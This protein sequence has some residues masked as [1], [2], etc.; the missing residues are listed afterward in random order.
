MKKYYSTI[1]NLGMRVNIPGRENEVIRFKGHFFETVDV[2]LQKLLEGVYLF[3]EKKIYIW[4]EKSEP[5][6]KS[7]KNDS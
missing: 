3:H 7:K 2:E 6:R 1:K 5:V 4:E